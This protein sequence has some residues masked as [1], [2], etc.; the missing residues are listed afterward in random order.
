MSVLHVAN[1]LLRVTGITLM[2]TWRLMWDA[3]ACSLEDRIDIAA[4]ARDCDDLPKAGR[5]GEVITE[6]DG[7]RVQVMHNGLRVLADAFEGTWMT[8]LIQR[9]RGH[10]EP[11]E[12]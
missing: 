2:P 8:Q 12:E 11:Q 9:C 10:H 1:R 4:R 3:N 6:A 7:A 5:S